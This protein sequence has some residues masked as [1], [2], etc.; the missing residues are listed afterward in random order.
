MVIRSGITPEDLERLLR[1][2]E[3]KLEREQVPIHIR[4]IK[5]MQEVAHTLGIA[6]PGGPPAVVAR[7][8]NAWIS[9]AIHARYERSYGDRL[10]MDFSIG[11]VVILVRGDLWTL[12]IPLVCGSE[13]GI[14]SVRERIQK[15]GPTGGSEVLNAID[16][17]QDLP[18]GVRSSLSDEELKHALDVCMLGQYAF[19]NFSRIGDENLLRAALSDHQDAVSQLTAQ[20]RHCGHSQWASLQATEKTFKA[21][22]AGKGRQYSR[23]NH[24][25]ETYA[26]EAENAGLPVTDRALLSQIQCK[27]GVRYGEISVTQDE[28]LG[29]HHAALKVA[30]H[31]S[32]ACCP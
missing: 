15:P 14:V 20:R 19:V 7:L 3:R 25:L 13:I 11:R 24:N 5:A 28:A 32:N 4:P 18:D 27:P 1:H 16:C 2:I 22:V 8:P 17:I 30:K 31:V 12:R 9:E 6:L 26:K 23:G 29:A 21:F 10:K